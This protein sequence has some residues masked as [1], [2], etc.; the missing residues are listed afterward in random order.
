MH[1]SGTTSVN[2]V[3]N[4]SSQK[5]E[6]AV[7]TVRMDRCIA[8]RFKLETPAVNKRISDAQFAQNRAGVTTV[9]MKADGFRAAGRTWPET[10]GSITQVSRI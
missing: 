4:C 1:V 9:L 7:F 10:R 8:R 6:T 3:V 5:R 2:P